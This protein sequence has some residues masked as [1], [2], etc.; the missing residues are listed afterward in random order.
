[1]DTGN[2]NATSATESRHIFG[3]HQPSPVEKS[4]FMQTGVV[5]LNFKVV[6]KHCS[7]STNEKHI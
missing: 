5:R 2:G 7:I 3:E 1:M 4:W 6:V